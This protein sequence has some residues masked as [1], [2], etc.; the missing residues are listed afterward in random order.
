MVKEP[1]PINKDEKELNK[2]VDK[3]V[4]PDLTSD[5]YGTKEQKEIVELV[6]DDLE[7]GLASQKEWLNVKKLELQHIHAEKPSKI[8][9]LKKR[10]WMSDRNLGIMPGLLDIYQA[11]LLSTCW[12]PNTFHYVAT[13]SNDV[14]QRDNAAKFTKWGM[15]KSEANAFPEVDDFIAN[16]V[17]HGFSMFKVM[18]EVSYKWVDKR[19]PKYS[20]ILGRKNRIVSYEIKTEERRFEK[21]MIRNI[22][23]VD[24][25]IIPSYG[26]HVQ[27]LEFFIERIHTSY[28]ELKRMAKRKI[29]ENFSLKH[30]YQNCV[31]Q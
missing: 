2:S 15:G 24:D 26:K 27:E 23:N 10:S 14:D 7:A 31:Q 18:W 1:N 17:G 22:D 28:A 29:I 6:M 21:G 16:R 11:T 25:I 12:N 30:T 9:N 3:R 13:E 19:V 8:E 4:E 20:R 5:S